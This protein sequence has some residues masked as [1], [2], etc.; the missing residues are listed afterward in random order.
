MNKIDVNSIL[1]AKFIN[2]YQSM[3]DS[4]AHSQLHNDLIKYQWEVKGCQEDNHY[5]S[6][7][8][9]FL[10]CHAIFLVLLIS[11]SVSALTF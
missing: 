11:T 10:S 6:F 8:L 7:C 3:R 1:F 9:I 5:D 4:N 2:N